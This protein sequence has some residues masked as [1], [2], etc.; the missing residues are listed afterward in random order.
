[1][2]LRVLGV[3]LEERVGSVLSLEER[4]G[5]VRIGR[6]ANSLIRHFI[7]LHCFGECDGALRA[8]NEVRRLLRKHFGYR[9]FFGDGTLSSA[10]RDYFMREGNGSIGIIQDLKSFEQ[11]T[12]D[13]LGIQFGKRV[14]FQQAGFLLEP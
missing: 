6:G 9:D 12:K 2:H 13:C 14:R 7:T 3:S 8:R 4:V 11:R 5:I 10:L 1:M